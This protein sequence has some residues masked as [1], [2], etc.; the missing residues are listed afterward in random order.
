MALAGLIVLTNKGEPLA[1]VGDNFAPTALW[2]ALAGAAVAIVGSYLGVGRAG[3]KLSP[4]TEA[5]APSV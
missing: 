4:K 3:M 5:S 1:V 2:L